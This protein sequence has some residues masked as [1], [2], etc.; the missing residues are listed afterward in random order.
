[1]EAKKALDDI[2]N[3]HME[4]MKIE[5]SIL[6]L[7]QLFMDMA[8][9]VAAQGEVIDQIAVHVESAVNDTDAGATELK[10]AVEIQKKTRKKM[11][12]IVTSLFLISRYF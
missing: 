5:K 9:L 3:K 8:V 12:I 2:Q 1:M 6:E 7:Q 11:C 10:K 4:V